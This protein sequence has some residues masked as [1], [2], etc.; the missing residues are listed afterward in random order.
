M[1]P[2]KT[3]LKKAEAPAE[4]T[5]PVVEEIAETPAAEVVT[6]A[7][8]DQH[9]SIIT[10]L[11]TY[12]TEFKE[13]ITIVKA[14]QKENAKLVKMTTKKSKK[15]PAAGGVARAPSGFAKPTLLS[16]Q[17]CNFLD[18]P[19]GSSLARTD[20]TRI[21][22]N[23]IKENKLQNQEDK[24]QI[25]PDEKLKSILMY[26]EGDKLSYFNLQSSMKHQFIKAEAV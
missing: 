8:V 5:A 17:L 24:R 21:I 15:T 6:D 4:P 9:A 16:D 7:P 10:K 11:Q 26:K 1:A 2:K 20:V 3:T 23:Y 19:T 22:N 14:L 13:M 12:I 25:I 18:L